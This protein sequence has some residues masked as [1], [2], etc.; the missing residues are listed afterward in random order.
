MRLVAVWYFWDPI[1]VLGLFRPRPTRSRRQ[2][3]EIALL[4]T[5]NEGVIFPFCLRW[6]STGRNVSKMR[7]ICPKDEPKCSQNMTPLQKDPK[8]REVKSST[9]RIPKD[10]YLPVLSQ[11][12]KF[13]FSAQ[14]SRKINDKITPSFFVKSRVLSKFWRLERVG[15]GRNSPKTSTGSQKYH[16]ATSFVTI[17]MFVNFQKIWKTR[18]TNKNCFESNATLKDS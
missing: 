17:F 1:E 11:H 7:Q 14:R 15:R 18:K 5:K 3:F 4:L 16:T 9:S 10:S 8:Q 6:E 2:K 12:I 13:E